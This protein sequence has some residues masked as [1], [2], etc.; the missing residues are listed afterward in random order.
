L[1]VL[2]VC[3]ED[4][5]LASANRIRNHAKR[6]ESERK[7]LT[8][9]DQPEGF[10]GGKSGLNPLI[11][12][13]STLTDTDVARLLFSFSLSWT[14]NK[15]NSLTRRETLKQIKA[16]KHASLCNVRPRDPGQ[17]EG[18][19]KEE[20]YF[21]HLPKQVLPLHHKLKQKHENP[22]RMSFECFFLLLFCLF[23]LVFHFPAFSLESLA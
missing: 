8:L 6:V 12:F 7:N 5:A 1:E 23:C 11:N 4:F 15:K 22:I 9:Y 13:F 19:K 21:L 10:L 20:K 16:N 14:P 2:F 18:A 17:E 3:G